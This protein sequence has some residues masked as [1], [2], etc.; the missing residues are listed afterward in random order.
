MAIEEQ[1]QH[2]VN[3]P[4]ISVLLHQHCTSILRL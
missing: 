3:G 4:L 1:M 2:L